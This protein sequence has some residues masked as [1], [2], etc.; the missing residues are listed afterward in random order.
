MWNPTAI[1]RQ[2][3]T[4]LDIL[5]AQCEDLEQLLVLARQ[6]RLA[7]EREDFEELIRV[8]QSRGALEGQLQIHQRQIAD[9]RQ[10]L[11]EASMQGL[12]KTPA[13]AR[14]AELVNGILLQDEQTRPLLLAV[15]G[16]IAE[17]IRQ[18]D[19]KRRRMKAYLRE[20]GK[21]VSA[22]DQLA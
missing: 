14:A 1:D 20:A 18:L 2:A 5:I 4:L 12:M 11:G 13:A 15:R 17:E 16:G 3:D 9:L 10:Q 7:V 19:L 22:C 6:E 21:N 8:V